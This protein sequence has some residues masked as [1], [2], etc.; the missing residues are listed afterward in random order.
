M[1]GERRDDMGAN[2]PDYGR[3][4]FSGPTGDQLMTHVRCFP[5]LLLT[6]F[7]VTIPLVPH[8]AYA[9]GHLPDGVIYDGVVDPPFTLRGKLQ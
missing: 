3:D 6:A 8:T 7:F 1:S 5:I 4:R 9:G 2:L